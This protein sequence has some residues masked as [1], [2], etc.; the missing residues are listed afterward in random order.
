MREKTG[1]RRRKLPTGPPSPETTQHPLRAASRQ[2]R[3]KKKNV[4]GPQVGGASEEWLAERKPGGRFDAASLLRHE[5]WAALVPFIEGLNRDPAEIL[6][7]LA[8]YMA[9]LL[10]WNRTA[11]NLVSRADE[12]RLVSRHLYESLEPAAWITAAGAKVC[13]DFGSGAG[14][15][16]LPLAI[17]GVGT[18]WLLVESRRP[19]V[20][21]L[22]GVVQE[23]ALKHV[24]PIHARLEE[25]IAGGEYEDN[26][27]QHNQIDVFVSR[28][29]MPLIPTL[30]LAA[31][32]LG[33]GGH[34]FL[35]KGSR[36]D[37]EWSKAG[38]AAEQWTLAETRMLGDGE[39]AVQ[40]FILNG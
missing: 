18:E 15:P 5:D 32:I 27:L 38:S 20:L 2:G 29:T 4:L 30:E 26:D 10:T 22:R 33:P 9:R 35:W 40:K 6:P 16:G 3:S 37:E 31:D 8:A 12:S 17:L 28:A 14:F 34:A 7:R 21:F 1:R 36:R 24:R 25:V 19:K 11:S 39:V 23:L 13:L